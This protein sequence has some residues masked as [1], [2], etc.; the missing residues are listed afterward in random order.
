MVL[1]VML[2]GGP[3]FDIQSALW[4]F[5]KRSGENQLKQSWCTLKASEL[6]RIK[7]QLE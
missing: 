2:A 4:C 6:H 7:E 3:I 1:Q 5:G